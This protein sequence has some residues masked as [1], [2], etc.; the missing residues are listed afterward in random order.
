MSIQWDIIW[1]YELYEC[2]ELSVDSL[3][4]KRF[5]PFFQTSWTVVSIY[6]ILIQILQK[7]TLYY[8]YLFIFLY[9]FNF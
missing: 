2:K 6:V 7:L 5:F 3:H 1:E 4:F 9:V 8:V